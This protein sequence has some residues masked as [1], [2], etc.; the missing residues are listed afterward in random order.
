M[1]YINVEL[2]SEIQKLN[3]SKKLTVFVT[4]KDL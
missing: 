2:R 4:L 1:W 3:Y